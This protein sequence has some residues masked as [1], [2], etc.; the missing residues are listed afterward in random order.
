MSR[1]F[2]STRE[3][4]HTEKFGGGANGLARLHLPRRAAMIGLQQSFHDS[5]RAAGRRGSAGEQVL[6]HTQAGGEVVQDPTPLAGVGQRVVK[7]LS[8]AGLPAPPPLAGVARTFGTPEG[9]SPL[10]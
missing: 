4:L 9:F 5:G 10:P 6:A 3:P 7:D 1:C 2:G 8:W